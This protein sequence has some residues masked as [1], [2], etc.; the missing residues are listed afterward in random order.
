MYLN[1]WTK[2]QTGDT[3]KAVLVWIY[4]G[5]FSGGS[6]S[7]P[8]NNGANIAELE[9]VVVVSFK[10]VHLW[11]LCLYIRLI[12]M[13]EQLPAEHSRIPGKPV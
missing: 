10:C 13:L 12:L 9:D 6:A 11:I 2:P 8:G 7:V 3:K 1:V 5:G 4:G